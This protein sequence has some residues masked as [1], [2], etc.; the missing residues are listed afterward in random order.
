MAN[1]DADEIGPCLCC[2]EDEAK[3]PIGSIHLGEFLSIYKEIIHLS[4]EFP[5]PKPLWDFESTCWFIEA[6]GAGTRSKRQG[7][8]AASPFT[9]PSFV[10]FTSSREADMSDNILAGECCMGGPAE[11]V[12]CGLLGVTMLGLPLGLCG[13]GLLESV[14]R[15]APPCR[16]PGW[17]HLSGRFAIA[18]SGLM[19]VAV[20]VAGLSSF[21]QSDVLFTLGEPAWRRTSRVRL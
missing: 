10:Q 11:A 5:G 8:R 16:R 1:Y 15:P 14:W 6:E 21:I 9:F 4:V 13:G 20:A 19:L 12:I 7:K 17:F 3:R 18:I 2:L